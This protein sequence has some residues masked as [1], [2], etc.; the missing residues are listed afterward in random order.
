MTRQ[1]LN[2]LRVDDDASAADPEASTAAVR[3]TS[4]NAAAEELDC[5]L[6]RG[7]LAYGILAATLLSGYVLTGLLSHASLPVDGSREWR[8]GDLAADVLQ[9]LSGAIVLGWLVHIDR[10]ARVRWA[11]SHPRKTALS[12]LLLWATSPVFA[13]FNAAPGMDMISLS[14]A[15]RQWSTSAIATIAVA[16]VCALATLIRHLQL[17]WRMLSRAGF[18]VYVLRQGAIV[19]TYAVAYVAAQMAHTAGTEVRVPC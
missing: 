4:K 5:Y 8:G 1:L 18:T 17:A 2:M 14:G 9:V 12:V 3:P 16:S 15:S 6:V 13:A 19:V 10:P 11:C 7:C